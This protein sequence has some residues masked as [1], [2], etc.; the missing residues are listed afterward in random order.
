[1]VFFQ[2]SLSKSLQN[3]SSSSIDIK[4]SRIL[5]GK[6]EKIWRIQIFILKISKKSRDK[7]LEITWSQSQ[8]NLGSAIDND[9]ASLCVWKKFNFQNST[10][11]PSIDIGFGDI[12]WLKTIDFWTD[13]LQNHENIGYFDWTQLCNHLPDANVLT[14]VFY[15][16]REI[17]TV[18]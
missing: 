11:L 12:F 5:T 15:Q 1:M 13:S 10:S 16:F 7:S 17:N 4:Y 9:A 14:Q 3:Y 2:G 18:G 6:L 8:K